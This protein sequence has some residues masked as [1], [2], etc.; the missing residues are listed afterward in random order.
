LHLDVIFSKGVR[1]VVDVK[2]ISR[3]GHWIF[4]NPGHKI[5]ERGHISTYKLWITDEEKEI[6]VFRHKLYREWLDLDSIEDEADL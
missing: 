5:K 6:K 1:E 3:W 4:E 2:P